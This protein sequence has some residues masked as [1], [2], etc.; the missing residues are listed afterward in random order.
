MATKAACRDQG[1]AAH[2]GH[3]FA[4]SAT[5]RGEV[6]IQDFDLREIED[7]AFNIVL[8]HRVQSPLW[9]ADTVASSGSA[10][11][12]TSRTSRTFRTVM[13]SYHLPT[14]AP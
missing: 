3:H 4:V 9:S 13:P 1:F 11:M 2:Q 14:A 7:Q 8:F 5:V 6:R 10:G 12:V